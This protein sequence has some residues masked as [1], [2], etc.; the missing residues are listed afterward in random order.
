MRRDFEQVYTV[1]F[2]GHRDFVSSPMLE[3]HVE[4]VIKRIAERNPMTDILIG[5]NGEFDKCVASVVKRLK[6]QSYKYEDIRLILVLP[7]FTAEYTNNEE[8]FHNYYDDVEICPLSLEAHFKA[9][10]GIRNRYMIDRSDLSVFYV[11]RKSGGAYQ[12]M[13]YAMQLNKKKI[14]LSRIRKS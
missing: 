11:N 5:R 3:Y 10:I 1:S 7:Y 6:K 12:T 13:K 2:F 8:S 4:R 14:N 9:A